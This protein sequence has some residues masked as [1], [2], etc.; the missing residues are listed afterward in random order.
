[1]HWFRER[2][3]DRA[4]RVEQRLSVQSTRV[5]RR[6]NSR[7]RSRSRSQVLSTNQERMKPFEKRE[8]L[9]GAV[10]DLEDNADQWTDLWDDWK[11]FFQRLWNR[12]RYLQ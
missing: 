2:R 7:S 4:L 6:S 12:L 5:G 11:S 9:E 8:D 10:L 1:M 3:A